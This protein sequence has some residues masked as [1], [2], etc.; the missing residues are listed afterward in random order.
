MTTDASTITVNGHDI[1]ADLAEDYERAGK[2]PEVRAALGAYY[3]ST[4]NPTPEGAEAAI[5]PMRLAMATQRHEARVSGEAF[6]ASI[7][8]GALCIAGCGGLHTFRAP[9]ALCD[10][11]RAV[12]GRLFA[13]A[14]SADILADGQTRETVVRAY[15]DARSVN[16]T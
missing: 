8:A 9:D 3:T 13:E 1:P 16:H 15:L 10:E 12:K 2:A 4:P 6:A 11:C 14:A 7:H 5:H